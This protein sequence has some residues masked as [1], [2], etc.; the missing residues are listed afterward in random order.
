[1]QRTC[2]LPLFVLVALL[3]SLT[4][5]G[6][7]SAADPEPAALEFFEKK[8]RPVLI[9]RCYECHSSKNKEPKGGLRAD[10]LAALLKGGETGPGVVPGKT[11][12][13][14]IIDA[15]NYGELYQMPPKGK[16]PADEIDV[17][18]KWV[19]MGAPW[20]A[21]KDPSEGLTKDFDLARRKAEHWCWQPL[22]QPAL[23][24]VKNEAW[25]KQPSDRFILTKLETAGLSPAPPADKRT[26][27][28]RVYFDLIGLPPTP[29][30][31]AQ[32]LKD[33]SPTA[34]EKVVDRLLQSPH[35]GERW[36]RHWLDL[37]RYAES[38]GHE[39]DYT[40]P[41]AWQYRDY[42]IRAI[43]ADVP[44]DQFMTEHIAG[45]LM[46]TPRQ[47][48]EKKFN[49]SIL[50]TGFWFLGEWIHSP[51][52]IRKDETDRFDNMVD[53]FSKSFLGLTVTCAR[54]H[55]HKFD[56]ISQKDYYA[57][58]G[59]LQSSGHRLVRF[60]TQLAE[61]HLARELADLENTWRPKIAAAIA[62]ENAAG[63]GELAKYLLAAREAIQSGNDAAAIAKSQQLSAI[64]LQAWLAQ[65]AEAQK[66]PADPLHFWA[67]IAH[68]AKAAEPT[69]LA[70]L[71]AKLKEAPEA[72]TYQGEWIVDYSKLPANEWFSNGVTFGLAP[73]TTG[74]L[75][76]GDGKL[77]V[78][79]YGAAQRDA[80]WNKL[81]IDGEAEAGKL[82]YPR[83][84][85]TIRTKTFVLKD[86]PVHYLVKGAGHVYAAVDSHAMLNGPLHGQ[87]IKETGGNGE[88]APRWITQDLKGYIG[89]N[90]H[91]E[92]TPKGEEDLQVLAVAQGA[93]APPLP[94]P[95]N[96]VSQFAKLLTANESKD[97]SSLAAAYEQRFVSSSKSLLAAHVDPQLDVAIQAQLLNLLVAQPALWSEP[98]TGG[99]SAEAELLGKTSS[100]QLQ[101]EYQAAKQKLVAA[102]PLKS[103]VALAMWDGSSVDEHLLIR[104]NSSQKTTGPLVQRRL[105]EAIEADLA[106][107]KTVPTS[108]LSTTAA[109]PEPTGS[110]RLKL[111]EKLTNPRNPFPSRVMVNRIW[112]HLFG[113]GIV[114]SVDNFGVLGQAPTHPELLDHLALE[115]IADGWS[116][117]RAIR[118]LMLSNVYQMASGGS[119][120]DRSQLAIGE[121]RDP[122]NLLFHKAQLRRLEGEVIRDS[123]LHLSGRLDSKQFGPSVPVHLTAFMQG[124]GRPGSGP[125]DGDGRRSIYLGIR[126]NFLSSMMLAFDVPNPASTIGKRNVSNVPAQALILMNDPLVSEQA[127][128]WAKRSLITKDIAPATRIERL[129][130]EAFSRPATSDEIAAANEFLKTQGT[131]YGVAADSLSTDERIWADLCHVLMNS[132]EFVFIR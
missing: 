4:I 60:E 32:F 48:P 83:A 72:A 64:R 132:K 52:D 131:E 100:K 105:L 73:V 103:Q 113:R 118:R 45:D 8:V 124:R 127:K 97:L 39:F 70:E 107:G 29:E 35:F 81:V 57:L 55:D 31:V 40:I 6:L 46:R 77:S 61:E 42:V 78:A 38:R 63:A 68:D 51:V 123:I 79:Q 59:Y 87:L 54:C 88:T 19:E 13:S 122:Q 101:A 10:S 66:N 43:N 117:K 91:L 85:R 125:L 23:P 16:L 34:L 126:R 128:L 71:V 102:G 106:A 15:V 119:A 121:Q 20:P 110:G 53:V 80:I 109:T 74:T 98:T 1:M 96:R 5:E 25:V 22:K 99:Q 24:A 116:V 12:E 44:Y 37:M 75:L 76:L 89:H 7:A 115:F 2:R 93:T 47:N 94:Y 69:R 90:A 130:E 50:G 27:I 36:G 111:A 92:F 120:L 11:K 3:L 56:A 95:L 82:A 21:E 9:N 108:T 65:L 62:G 26:L 84:G 41:G 18:T 30:E 114:P 49:E 112:H 28:R 58:F 67:L 104:G 17:L 14:L 86:G 33:D 129:Y